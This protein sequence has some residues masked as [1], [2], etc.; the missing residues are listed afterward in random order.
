MVVLER[1]VAFEPALTE[2]A[3]VAKAISALLAEPWRAGF[4]SS[5]APIRS[6]IFPASSAMRKRGAGFRSFFAVCWRLFQICALPPMP[7]LFRP[8]GRMIQ[9]G[10]GRR[11]RRG[12]SRPLPILDEWRCKWAISHRWMKST[13][14][15]RLVASS[16]N[17]VVDAALILR[18]SSTMQRL[19]SG[20]AFRQYTC[21]WATSSRLRSV[22]LP[23]FMTVVGPGGVGVY[24]LLEAAMATAS[25]LLGFGVGMTVLRFVPEHLARCEYGEAVG[26]IRGSTLLLFATSGLA[27][28]VLLLLLPWIGNLWPSVEG[29]RWGDRD[30]GPDNSGVPFCLFLQQAL[31]GFQEIRSI[32]VGSSL[33]QLV[34]KLLLTVGVFAA[35]LG[36]DGYILASVLASLSGVVWLSYSLVNQIRALPAA[37]PTISPLRKWL[38]FAL[39]SLSGSL[40]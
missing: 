15:Y 4:R 3:D 23:N 29:Y 28:V 34:M 14:H 19:P 18:A 24:G 26:L 7:T 35:G 30:N 22:H 5:Y 10:S 25:G 21:C 6:I 2:I 16:A 27:C 37:T 31:R 17:S 20:L 9:A 32:I 39:A 40:L 8:G 38:R 33:I 1:N 12:N 13:W 11:R 36:L